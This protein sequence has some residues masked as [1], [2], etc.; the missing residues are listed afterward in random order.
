MRVLGNTVLCCCSGDFVVFLPDSFKCV[1]AKPTPT[2]PNTVAPAEQNV[3]CKCK[4]EENAGRENNGK[5][6]K[7][8]N[9][10]QDDDFKPRT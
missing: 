2:P 1:S 5:K 10:Q 8:K 6:G 3:G 7:V 9:S 4:A